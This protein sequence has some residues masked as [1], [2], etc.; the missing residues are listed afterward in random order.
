MPCKLTRG[1][2]LK[3]DKFDFDLKPLKLS[4][5]FGD[6]TAELLVALF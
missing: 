4:R 1:I 5:L 3:T 6:T 2:F